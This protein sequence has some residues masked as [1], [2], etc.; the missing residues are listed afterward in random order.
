VVGAG[1]AGGADAEVDGGSHRLICFAFLRAARA[2]TRASVSMMGFGGGGAC[3]VMIY[4]VQSSGARGSSFSAHS[5]SLI[6]PCWPGL[7][8]PSCLQNTATPAA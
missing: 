2:R 3:V 7:S 6:R 1:L 5:S 4:P 8:A